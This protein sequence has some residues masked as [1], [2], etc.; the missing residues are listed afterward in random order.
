[1]ESKLLQA[2]IVKRLK[3][4]DE[5][6]N[7]KIRDIEQ[8]VDDL[9][10]DSLEELMAS[11]RLRELLDSIAEDGH[12]RLVE[13]VHDIEQ[14]FR[15]L[16]KDST[17]EIQDK[18][19]ADFKSVVASIPMPKDGQD[20]ADGING[21]DGR[22][23]ETPIKGLHYWT[24]EDKEKIV[25]EV[26]KKVEPVVNSALSPKKVKKS[27]IAIDER[28]WL[29]VSYIKDLDKLSFDVS[30]IKDIERAL[31]KRLL[32]FAGGGSTTSGS[33]AITVKESDGSPSV[34]DVTTIVF[35]AGTVTDDG[36][37]QVTVASGG[38]GG[39][40][41]KY[42][43]QTGGT[44]DTY[45]TLGGTINGV[46]TTFTVSQS[47]YTSGTLVVY[48]NGVRQ[49]QGSS[50]GWTE[51]TPGSGTFDFTT[52]PPSGSRVAVEYFTSTPTSTQTDQSGGTSDTYGVLA[53]TINGS[54]AT[55]TVSQSSYTSGSLVVYLNGIRQEQGSSEGW[56]ETTPGSG[57]FAFAT[58][59]PSGSRISVDYEY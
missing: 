25:S 13:V 17:G 21:A 47:T 22:D 42:I 2:V 56:T 33:G 3:D 48:L 58:A 29:P 12:E 20:G 28:E 46:N 38:G 54:N 27:I 52:A 51:S 15:V 24:S 11:K 45:G 8:R 10:Y 31:P 40:S 35:S 34:S 26:S 4:Y 32:S 59:P 43:D 37:G 44:G 30:Q 41:T 14:D 53:G 9:V 55:F 18:L 23:G 50:E 39:S 1:M 36:G 7:L 16:M 6:L 5:T 19:I 49:E 57:T